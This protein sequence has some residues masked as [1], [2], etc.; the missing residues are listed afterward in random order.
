MVFILGFMA[1]AY[2]YRN[3]YKLIMI[4]GKKGSGKTTLLTKLSLRYLKAGRPV[5]SNVPYPVHIC[6]MLMILVLRPSLQVLSSS[7]MRSV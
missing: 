4:F 3:P 7:W 6:L 2:R 5:Y 1:F